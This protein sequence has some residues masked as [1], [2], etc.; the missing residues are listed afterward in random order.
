M[1][2]L[3][4]EYVV[5]PFKTPRALRRAFMGILREHFWSYPWREMCGKLYFF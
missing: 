4:Y 5:L 1:F 2:M 3:L